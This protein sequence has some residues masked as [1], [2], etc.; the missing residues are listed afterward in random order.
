MTHATQTMHPVNTILLIGPPGSGKGTQARLLAERLGWVRLSSGERIKAIRDGDE[1]F[2]ER[3]RALYD[4]GTLLPDWFADYLLERGLLELQPHVGVVAEG[5]GRTEAQAR[6]VVD[7]LA[8]LGRPLK[9]MH[10]TLSDAEATRRML[11]RATEEDRPDS[12]NAAKAADRLAHY[13]RETQPAVEHFRTLG[14][15]TDIDG[16]PAPESV[17]AA[18]E[19][20]IAR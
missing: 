3:V 2:S 10:L 8:W 17:A 15:V 20:A 18:I 4:K 14:L 7:I 5:F 11:S 6:H 12:D 16:S 19:T 9:V 1:P 13:V